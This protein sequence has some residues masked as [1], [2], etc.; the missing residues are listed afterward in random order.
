[1]SDFSV[2]N[3]TRNHKLK[4]IRLVSGSSVHYARAGS[5]PAS[6]TKKRHPIGVL[7][8]GMR[9]S[10]AGLEQGGGAAAKNSPVDCFSARGKV[11]PRAP[12]T[13]KSSDLGL[14][15]CL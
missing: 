5:S 4:H 1:M 14:F 13:L 9:I 8:F 12:K 10:E 6:R 15:F 3:D 2:L 7:F 11:P